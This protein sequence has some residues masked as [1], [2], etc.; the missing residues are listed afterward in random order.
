MWRAIR[1]IALVTAFLAAIAIGDEER[2][3]D[4]DLT[5]VSILVA[6]IFALSVVWVVIVCFMQHMIQSFVRDFRRQCRHEIK[7][8]V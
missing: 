4:T 5:E 6:C 2:E 7:M 1:I 3:F 8:M